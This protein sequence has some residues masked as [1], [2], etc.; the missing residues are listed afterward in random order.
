MD[1]Q[2]SIITDHRFML[3]LTSLTAAEFFQL[4]APIYELWQRY[5][6]HHELQG[7]RW[8]IEKFSEYGSMCL[9]GSYLLKC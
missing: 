7:K 5:H 9:K 6:A 3:S 1:N 8:G 2:Y 4:L